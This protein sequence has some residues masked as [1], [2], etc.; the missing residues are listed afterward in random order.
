MLFVPAPGSVG[1]E[2]GSAKSVAVG[3]LAQSLVERGRA[4]RG[5]DHATVWGRPIGDALAWFKEVLVPR[6]ELRISRIR[7]ILAVSPAAAVAAFCSLRGPAP[8][9]EH[10][11]RAFLPSLAESAPVVEGLRRLDDQ[12]ALLG[13]QLVGGSEASASVRAAIFGKGPAALGH[14]SAEDLAATA[15]WDG[16]AA[17]WPHLVDLAERL[18]WTRGALAAKL[19]LPADRAADFVA[20]EASRRGERSAERRKALADSAPLAAFSRGSRTATPYVEHVGGGTRCRRSIG[21]TYRQLNYT[22]RP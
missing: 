9:V 4:A 7:E 19:G 16:L 15:P 18:G 11:L 8:L 20:T 13:A 10:A 2:Y 12:W 5:A 3:G 21:H 17:A 14:R 22:S 1:G 6:V